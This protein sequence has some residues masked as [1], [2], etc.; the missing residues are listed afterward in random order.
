MSALLKSILL[1]SERVKVGSPRPSLEIAKPILNQ[2]NEFL[3]SSIQSVTD[4]LD[5]YVF[6]MTIPIPEVDQNRDSIGSIRNVSEIVIKDKKKLFREVPTGKTL[7]SFLDKDDRENFH[8]DFIAA[9]LDTEKSGDFAREFFKQILHLTHGEVPTAVNSIRSRREISLGELIPGSRNEEFSRRRIDIW[10]QTSNYILVIENKINSSESDSQTTD[11]H[12]AVTQ[13]NNNLVQPKKVIEILLAPTVI[14]PQCR[15]YVSVTYRDLYLIL[16]S[17]LDK[18]PNCSCSHY[19][20]LY[21]NSLY[22]FYYRDEVL[23]QDFLNSFWR[24]K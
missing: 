3:I 23:Y 12:N 5:S 19:V 6:K 13:Y 2:N 9:F 18:M 24:S 17:I 14:P 8:S 1:V 10:A 15:S 22:E 20:E 21:L 4:L 11:Y 16:T 7:L